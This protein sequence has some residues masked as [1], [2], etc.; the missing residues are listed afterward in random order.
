MRQI[1]AAALIAVAVPAAAAAA[2]S[3]PQTNGIPFPAGTVLI[4]SPPTGDLAGYRITILPDGTATAEDGAGKGQQTL[5]PALL[6]TLVTD[7][8]AA[9]PIASLPLTACKDQPQT[10]TPII[11]TYRGMT[12][13]NIACTADPKGVAL[14]GD[15]QSIARAL[16]VANYRSRAITLHAATQQNDSSSS[17]QPQPQPQPQPAPPSMGGGYG[18]HYLDM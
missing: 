5:S 1:L 3:L 12:S 13:P 10:P 15:T 14:Y 9:M 6:K 16:Y 11:V 17:A 7:L 2:P 18:G 8:D 4:V